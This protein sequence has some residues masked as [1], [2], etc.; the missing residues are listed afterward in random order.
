MNRCI[1]SESESDG[2]EGQGI[3]KTII[4]PNMNDISTL[5][6]VILG[7]KLSGYT[8]TL[9]EASNIKDDL[10]KRNEFQNEQQYRKPPNKFHTQ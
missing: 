9:T 5:L 1:Q 6:E 10:Y 2:L 3:G 8:D 7:L 4:P